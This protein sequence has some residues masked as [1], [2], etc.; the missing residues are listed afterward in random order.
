[1]KTFFVAMLLYPD[2]QKK[3][4]DELGSVIGR[5]RLPTFDDRSRLPF[6]DAV[7]KET[8]RWQPLAPLGK[9][10]PSPRELSESCSFLPHPLR[11]PSHMLSHK[12]TSTQVSSYQRVGLY[13]RTNL[14]DVYICIYIPR[15]RSYWK[16]MVGY[17]FYDF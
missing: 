17:D 10:L 8:L 6:I 15:C 14:H 12:M 1:M 11:K 7:C 13:F 4:Q 5:D 9:F 2:I 3:A 16:C